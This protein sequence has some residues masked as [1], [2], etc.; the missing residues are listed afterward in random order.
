[1]TCIG[2]NS[3]HNFF[4]SL[5]DKKNIKIVEKPKFSFQVLSQDLEIYS[6]FDDQL[7]FTLEWILQEFSRKRNNSFPKNFSFFSQHCHWIYA[8]EDYQSSLITIVANLCIFHSCCHGCCSRWS[9]TYYYFII[10]MNCWWYFF[11]F[12]RQ[13]KHT[14]PTR[15]RINV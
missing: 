12:N 15:I 2:Y 13:K 9:V 14:H 4:F 3:S 11:L 5:F 10:E 1:M 7:I 8:H 6:V